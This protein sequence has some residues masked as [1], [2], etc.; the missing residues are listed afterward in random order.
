MSAPSA[1]IEIPLRRGEG[2]GDE[3]LEVDLNDLKG[4]HEAIIGILTQ[5]Q[6]PLRL[7]LEFAFQYYKRQMPDQLV[8][9]LEAGKNMAQSRDLRA[10]NGKEGEE[11]AYILILNSLASYRIESAKAQ[12]AGSPEQTQLLSAATQLLND[13]ERLN[14]R[15]PLTIVGKGNLMLARQNTD[16]ALYEFR[17]ALGLDSRFLPALIGV[18]SAH[19]IK[20]E[21]KDALARYQTILRLKPG[22]Q[23]DVRVPIGICF[24]RLNMLAEA[25]AAFKRAVDLNPSNVDAIALLSLMHTNKARLP[26]TPEIER[27]QSSAL[28]GSLLAQG[29]K[30]KLPNPVIDA[31]MAERYFARGE[32][33]KA[34]VFSELA[35]RH[36]RGSLSRSEALALKAR[37]VQAD[38]DYDKAFKLFS[39]AAV[40]NTDSIS[41]Q[42]GLGQMQ[43]YKNAKEDAIS[44]LERVLA[45]Q[46]DNYETLMIVA[47]LSSRSPDMATKA[48]DA[49]T[50][51]KK[52]LK[53]Y[54]E[55]DDKTKSHQWQGEEY[56]TDP[57]LLIEMGV[58]YEKTDV[59]KAQASLEQAIALLEATPDATIVPELLCNMGALYHVEAVQLLGAGGTAASTDDRDVAGST[60]A[61][62]THE[63]RLAAV[64]GL[65][66][67]AQTFYERA[68]ADVTAQARDDGA[69]GADD[70]AKRVHAEAV[71]TS[72][73]YNLARLEE[74][75]GNAAE[76]EEL[77]KGILA[78]HPAYIDCILRLG[79]IAVKRKDTATAFDR[80][81]DALAIDDKNALAWTMVA[82]IHLDNRAF[83][84]ARKLLEKVFQQIDKFDTYALCSYGNLCLRSIRVEP[85]SR[86]YNC[87][88]SVEFFH[89][90]LRHDPR[91]VYAA[92]GIALACAEMGNLEDARD[93]L[94]QIQ[95]AAGAHENVVINLAHVLVDLGLPKSAI[96][97]YES[98]AKRQDVVDLD[99]I[100]S[101]ARAYYFIAK[102]EKLP[103]SM[104]TVAERLEEA[105]KL[106]PNDLALKFNL[107]LAKQQYAQILN[108]QPKEKRP[109]EA[110]K[111]A[112]EGLEVSEKIFEELG[113]RKPEPTLAYDVERARERA[114]YSRGVRRVTDKKIHETEV[115]EKQRE[116]RLAEI[117]AKREEA[118][119]AKR[120]EE[121][122]KKSEEQ[123]R[124]EDLERR[125]REIQARVQEENEKMRL[126]LEEERAKPVRRKT[127]AAAGSDEGEDEEAVGGER[128]GRG[129]G[130]GDEDEDDGRKSKPKQKRK[131]KE[132]PSR[133]AASGDEDDEDDMDIRQKRSKGGSSGGTRSKLSATTVMDSD[134]D[135]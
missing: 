19:F 116:Q 26:S 11:A 52:L 3:V 91:N 54:H 81:S 46:P 61:H 34:R 88:R 112:A 29:F 118:L 57:E 20:G 132:K 6:A 123:R 98:V 27:E 66:Q 40:L 101:L 117:V 134:D 89:K 63:T 83:R 22:I 32:Y 9:F 44:S 76:A 58:F 79:A 122:A 119:E 96:P 43:I 107:A 69:D 13:A 72:V 41:I 87:K 37:V 47:A 75:R 110:L 51:L 39:E 128:R 84:P 74:T 16:Q 68:L 62:Q 78:D 8:M 53:S 67:K 102:T 14:S 49:F 10:M 97:F 65:L 2:H 18:A 82:M 64:A 35:H 109:L 60:V 15:N 124:L 100:R 24:H 129:R 36:S 105:L 108:D 133:E 7:F 25:Q 4:N 111:R 56:V 50:R 80:F 33:S 86:E 126:A 21:Y 42:F 17:A 114:N 127:A 38:G 45:K 120:R 103:D 31:Q 59:K 113:K 104:A 99:I 30:T 125:R 95:E 92:T 70:V 115:L 77:Y 48:A 5:E 1:T 23:P 106:S 130:D 85:K 131:R 121:E 71:R 12:P 93:L 73:R 135:E 90:A 94:T 55:D 28:A